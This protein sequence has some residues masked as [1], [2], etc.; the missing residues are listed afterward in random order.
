MIEDI[1]LRRTLRQ[2]CLAPGRVPCN[3]PVNVTLH[4]DGGQGVEV[5][6]ALLVADSMIIREM[7]EGPELEK[8]ISLVGVEVC[9]I[10]IYVKLLSSG[11]IKITDRNRYSHVL[12]LPYCQ[13]QVQVPGQ[14]QRTKD[15][16][17]G[18]T[19]KSHDPRSR[20]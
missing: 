15:L 6:L 11:E 12:D 19:L 17:L 1:I 16:G 10:K 8:H 18:Y 20:F 13:A 4:G 9:R 14:V 5:P 3:N 2:E 7:C